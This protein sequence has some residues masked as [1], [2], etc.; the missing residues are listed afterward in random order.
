MKNQFR[1][2]NAP[3][4]SGWSQASAT[5]GKA[6]SLSQSSIEAL[7]ASDG[8]KPCTAADSAIAD[9]SAVAGKAVLVSGRQA[10]AGCSEVESRHFTAVQ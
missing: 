4:R 7:E 2:G 10:R 3:S 1:S 9:A 8:L 5:R 6:A